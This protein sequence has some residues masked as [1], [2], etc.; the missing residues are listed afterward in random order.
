MRSYIYI[1]MVTFKLSVF[2]MFK[3][4][5]IFSLLG[6]K[7]NLVSLVSC[8]LLL[9]I[10][11]ALLFGLGGLLLPLAVGL[12]LLI[13]VSTMAYI[14]VFS[15]YFKI[16]EIMIIPYKE[17]HPEQFREEND[18]EQIMRDDVTQQKKLDEIKAR[19]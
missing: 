7:R 4:A 18:A 13:L 16:E 10:E 14:K 6:I 8:T 3:N 15:A 19:Q 11:A 1:Q 12:P 2:K 5:L 17:E 9:L